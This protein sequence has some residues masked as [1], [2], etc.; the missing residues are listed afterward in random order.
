LRA[1]R[2]LAVPE[3]VVLTNSLGRKLLPDAFSVTERPLLIGGAGQ[4]LSMVT[5]LRRTRRHSSIGPRRFLR[6]RQLFARRLGLST[7]ANAG[8]VHNV[9]VDGLR[10][11]FADLVHDVGEGLLVTELIGQVST[12]SPVTIH[13]VCPASGS[14]T[15]KSH[16][17]SKS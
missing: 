5:V 10:R 2:R 3:R 12:S 9:W 6:A 14:K 11:T 8:G 17:R 13:A 1:Q 15:V 7:T 4:R 16:F